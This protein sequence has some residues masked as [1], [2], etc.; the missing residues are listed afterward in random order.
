M[1]SAWGRVYTTTWTCSEAGGDLHVSKFGAWVWNK[2]STVAR[3]W[4]V[5]SDQVWISLT[6]SLLPFIRFYFWGNIWNG[7]K[8]VILCDL[9]LWLP[10]PRA[11]AHL[12]ML[13]LCYALHIQNFT[14][15]CVRERVIMIKKH[16]PLLSYIAPRSSFSPRVTRAG[17]L[18]VLHNFVYMFR[19]TRA[20][21]M[22][23]LRTCPF[24]FNPSLWSEWAFLLTWFL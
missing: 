21:L 5:V 16:A 1:I 15:E 10:V 17:G 6:F 22:W 13:R 20:P 11:L 8:L 12:K 7:Y 3:V 4:Y 14:D 19:L 2:G 9:Q 24:V 23:S 18:I